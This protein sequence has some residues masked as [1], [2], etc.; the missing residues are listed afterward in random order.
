MGVAHYEQKRLK[1]LASATS[2]VEIDL[3]RAPESRLR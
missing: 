2:L 1:V 3:F